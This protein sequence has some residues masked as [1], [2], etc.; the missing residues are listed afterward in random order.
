[1]DGAKHLG[2]PGSR[3]SRRRRPPNGRPAL[4]RERVRPIKVEACTASRSG[5]TNANIFGT[6]QSSPRRRFRR[7][8]GSPPAKRRPFVTLFDLM[9]FR[10]NPIFAAYPQAGQAWATAQ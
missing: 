8:A 9:D 5:S 1:V 6:T 3:R 4:D 10:F 7:S 2:R